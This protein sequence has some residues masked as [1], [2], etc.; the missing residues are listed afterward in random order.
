MLNEIRKAA[1]TQRAREVLESTARERAS[2]LM[3][4][5]RDA[6]I[7]ELVRLSES[8]EPSGA[9]A[10]LTHEGSPRAES[11]LCQ[12]PAHALDQRRAAFVDRSVAHAVSGAG[13][14]AMTFLD[15]D[16]ALRHERLRIDIGRLERAIAA[17]GCRI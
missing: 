9:D 16:D 14:G 1:C 5:E 10:N 12:S 2:R 4:R 7:D 11:R 3:L 8:V 17:V 6:L 13:Q 15:I